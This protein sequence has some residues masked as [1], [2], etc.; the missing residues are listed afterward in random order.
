MT[1][2]TPEQLFAETD[3]RYAAAYVDAPRRID[4]DDPAHD[5]WEENWLLIRDHVANQWADETFFQFFPTAG[6]LDPT[7]PN[8]EMLI[9]Y[10]NDI[11]NQIC[12]GG[13]GEWSWDNPPPA[14]PAA[15]P[16]RVEN[17]IRDEDHGG[18][19]AT[20]SAEVTEEQAQHVLW[21]DG[22]PSS[23]S[24][25][26]TSRFTMRVRLDLEAL[27]WMPEAISRMFSEAGMMT[28]D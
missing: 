17:V 11:R 2:P 21:P 23:A 20:F 9:R 1:L 5:D 10:W 8:D 4:P 14:P 25:E 19:I 12:N 3:R 16:I 15:P 18:F 6:K 13:P 7:D 27:R 26:S 24:V 28:A 22:M